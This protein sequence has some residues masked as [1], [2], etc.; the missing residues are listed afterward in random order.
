MK[1]VYVVCKDRNSFPLGVFETREDAVSLI[2][3]IKSLVEN[4]V[5]CLWEGGE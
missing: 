4:E 5:N 1:R 2:G 3:A